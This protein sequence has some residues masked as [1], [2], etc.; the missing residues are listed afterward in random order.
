[1][2]KHGITDRARA[3]LQAEKRHYVSGEFVAGG[4]KMPVLE[5]GTGAELAQVTSG[6]AA[7]IDAAVTAAHHAFREGSLCASLHL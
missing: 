5:P 3:F 7:E 4:E 6:S 1:I 2:E